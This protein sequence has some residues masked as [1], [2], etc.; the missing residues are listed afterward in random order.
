[1]NSSHLICNYNNNFLKIKINSLV[2]GGLAA[3]GTEAACSLR[4]RGNDK[5]DVKCIDSKLI[6]MT[7]LYNKKT[8]PTTLHL[9]RVQ[10]TQHSKYVRWVG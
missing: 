6:L 1:M 4:I 7:L 3:L 8:I 2:G 5:G 9:K 10:N